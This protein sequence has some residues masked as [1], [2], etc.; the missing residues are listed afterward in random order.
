MLRGA[1][2]WW[3]VVDDDTVVSGIVASVLEDEGYTVLIAADGAAGL[4]A[5]AREV[6]DVVLLDVRMPGLDGWEVLATYRGR[7]GTRA[8]VLIFTA[9]T[10]A[11]GMAGERGADGVVAKPFAL[12]DLLDAVRGPA[13]PPTVATVKEIA[14]ATA[15]AAAATREAGRRLRARSGRARKRLERV[16]EVTAILRRQWAPG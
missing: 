14:V 3:V 7:A 1:C 13:A 4:E 9:D 8:R 15:A 10:I 16:R 6:V 12:E 11:A 5:L 2:R